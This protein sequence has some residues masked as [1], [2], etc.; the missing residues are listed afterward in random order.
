MSFPAHLRRIGAILAVATVTTGMGA[1]L[2]CADTV[3][4]TTASA[5]A[6]APATT[7]S[8]PADR[9]TPDGLFWP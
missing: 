9:C 7:T 5:P 4:D 1:K 3:T 2:A 8:S 6:S